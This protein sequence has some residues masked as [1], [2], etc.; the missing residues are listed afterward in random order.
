MLEVKNLEITLKGETIIKSASFSIEKGK[1]VA[2]LGPSGSGKTTIA[3][4]LLDLLPK[5]SVKGEI[6]FQGSLQNLKNLR[7]KH[8]ALLLQQVQNTLNP[9]RRIKDQLI[10]GACFHLNQTK[11]EAIKAL[12]NLL[13]FMKIKNPEKRL[14]DLPHQFSG[15]EKQRLLLAQALLMRPSLLILDEPTSALDSDTKESLIQLLKEIQ[16]Q[17]TLSLL[18][19]THELDVVEALAE[20]VATLKEGVIEGLKPVIKRESLKSSKPVLPFIKKKPLVT[21]KNVE[22]R[23]NDQVILSVP[24][25]TLYEDEIVGLFGKS[26]SGK[27]TLAKL[28]TTWQKP[29]IGEILFQGKPLHTLSRRELAESVQMVFQD[30]YSALNPYLTIET[31]LKEGLE[32]FDLKEKVS[33]T[34]L[35]EQVK[36]PASFLFKK[37]QELS[38]GEKQRISL[39]RALSVNPKL[40]ILDEPTSALDEKT[41]EEILNLLKELQ[42]KKH[43][44]C[45]FISHDKD[46]ID[47]YCDRQLQVQV[48]TSH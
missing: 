24:S 22:K 23:Y 32:N 47:T 44:T 28:L 33:L 48:P 37:P 9:T 11:E 31:S 43:F 7:G 36:L 1:T 16:Q 13:H 6:L 2:L 12:L 17:F 39:V 19:I 30:P 21:L 4:S 41:A 10:E 14:N 40:L 15:G 27:T 35:M 25:M 45:L 46:K 18:I 5:G 3:L 20:S 38:G 42:R 26:G 8:I 29:D 34:T